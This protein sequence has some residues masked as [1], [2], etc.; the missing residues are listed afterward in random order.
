MMLS[1]KTLSAIKAACD[2]LGYSVRKYSGRAMYG[3]HCLGI[4]V[5]RYTSIGTVCFQVAHELVR[6]GEEDALEDLASVEWSNDSMGMGAI[7]YASS[8]RWE[9]DLE[10][11]E[12][13]E[14]EEECEEDS[15]EE[16]RI[17]ANTAE[18]LENL[19]RFE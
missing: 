17:D 7:V 16:R 6:A 4:D 14:D 18:H 10:D 12:G 5:D 19:D 9:G 2:N 1:A 8:L 13:D 3:S 15:A 11:E